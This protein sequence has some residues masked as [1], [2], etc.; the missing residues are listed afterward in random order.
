MLVRGHQV[1]VKRC[2]FM[3][4]LMAQHMDNILHLNKRAMDN[5]LHSNLINVHSNVLSYRKKT[6]RCV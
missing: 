2:F 5:I 4:L 6:I 1:R 3:L